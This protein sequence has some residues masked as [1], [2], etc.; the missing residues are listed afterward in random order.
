MFPVAGDPALFSFA[1]QT[2]TRRV[3]RLYL[4]PGFPSFPYPSYSRFFS[5]QTQTKGTKIWLK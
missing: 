3:S 1:L 2:S 5:R 4:K